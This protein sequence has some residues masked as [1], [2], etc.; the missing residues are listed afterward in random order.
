MSGPNGIELVSLTDAQRE[1]L[2]GLFAEADAQFLNGTPGA[3][4]AQVYDGHMKAAF[5]PQ[6]I[7]EQIAELLGFYFLGIG[8]ECG[9][10]YFEGRSMSAVLS[11]KSSHSPACIRLSPASHC[12]QARREPCTKVAACVCVNPAASRLAMISAGEGF[13][14][15]PFGP[16][17]G[18]FVTSINDGQMGFS[19]DLG[20]RSDVAVSSFQQLGPV[21][22]AVVEPV[23][24][25]ELF[26]ALFGGQLLGQFEDLLRILDSSLSA[27]ACHHVVDV[28]H[29]SLQAPDMPRR[30]GH[31]HCVHEHKYTLNERIRQPPKT[32]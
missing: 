24:G 7:A 18:W 14:E 3:V 32:H 22:G 13:A 17:L 11:L 26:I 4:P 29:F 15:G 19:S 31:K 8:F 27:Q 6:D 21:V 5:I 20:E 16:R 12:C 23:D 9:N 28:A 25:V 10:G 30:A 1:Q 2:A